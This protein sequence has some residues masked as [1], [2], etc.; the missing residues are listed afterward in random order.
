MPRSCLG[1]AGNGAAALVCL[2]ITI[3]TSAAHAETSI[4]V[5]VQQKSWSSAKPAPKTEKRVPEAWQH[6]AD[7][8]KVESERPSGLDPASYLKRMLEYEVTHEPGYHSTASGC[9]HRLEVELYPLG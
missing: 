4:C 6:A 2:S 3:A 1:R 7:P 8:A 5:E 9:G